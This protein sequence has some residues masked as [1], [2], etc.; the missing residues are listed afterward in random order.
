MWETVKDAWRRPTL[1]WVMALVALFMHSASEGE[2]GFF[3]LL[4]AFWVL[5]DRELTA[6]RAYEENHPRRLDT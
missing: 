1:P 5:G 2:L 6:R 4:A 3:T